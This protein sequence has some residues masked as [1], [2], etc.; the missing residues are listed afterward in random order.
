MT[1]G[2]KQL[3]NGKVVGYLIFNTGKKVYLNAKEKIELEDSIDYWQQ[4]SKY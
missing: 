2:S 4:T 1:Y 3:K